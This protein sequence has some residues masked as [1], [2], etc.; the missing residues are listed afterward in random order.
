MLDEGGC[1][2]SPLP[3]YLFPST[4]TH[5]SLGSGYRVFLVP[6]L[7]KLANIKEEK[8]KCELRGRHSDFYWVEVRKSAEK[9]EQS[10]RKQFVG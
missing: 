1:L 8:E 9:M 10:K 5:F 4:S 7:W 2:N 3:I 6:W